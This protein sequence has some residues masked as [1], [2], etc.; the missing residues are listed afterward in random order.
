MKIARETHF[1]AILIILFF[2]FIKLFHFPKWNNYSLK[3]VNHPLKFFWIVFWTNIFFWKDT[4]RWHDQK[5]HKHTTSH[6][7]HPNTMYNG[8]I[9]DH[10][11]ADS[12]GHHCVVDKLHHIR[13]SCAA[14][15]KT[16]EQNTR[17][18][19]GVYQ[20]SIVPL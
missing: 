6:T 13:W 16:G 11:F 14:D 9:L 1:H 10:K 20:K 17:K 15:F 2:D 18:L 5:H 19:V 4:H 3:F 12:G 8:Q 7:N